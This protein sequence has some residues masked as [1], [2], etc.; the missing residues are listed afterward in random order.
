MK[1]A[2]WAELSVVLVA[3][4]L[5]GFWGRGTRPQV[6]PPTPSINNSISNHLSIDGIAPGM[7]IK[8]TIAVLG[9]PLQINPGSS[10][11]PRGFTDYGAFE[12]AKWRHGTIAWFSE[13]KVVALTGRCVETSEGEVCLGDPSSTVQRTL[14]H[15]DLGDHIGALYVY[16]RGNNELNITI[17]H[18][19]VTRAELYFRPWPAAHA[20]PATVAPLAHPA[21]P[22]RTAPAPVPP[23]PVSPALVAPRS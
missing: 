15:V 13:Q 4:A 7:T 8:Q 22:A 1:R 5:L 14:G 10:R 11:T 3:A 2:A 18:D 16:W 12:R 19:R 17:D 20:S 9:Q 6:T 21:A 23:A